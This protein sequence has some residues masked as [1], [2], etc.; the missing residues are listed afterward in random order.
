MRCVGVGEI[1]GPDAM[2][3]NKCLGKVSRDTRFEPLNG[4]LNKWKASSRV[5][6]EVCDVLYR[7]VRG[8]GS[9]INECE[10]WFLG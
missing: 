8:E 7:L 2:G 4:K 10:H 1:Y 3:Y 5:G 9:V 6:I